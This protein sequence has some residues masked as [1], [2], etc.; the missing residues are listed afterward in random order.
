MNR[1]AQFQE[2]GSDNA[3]QCPWCDRWCLKD[4]ACDYVFSCGLDYTGT[5]VVGSGCGRTWCW[6]CGKKYCLPYHDAT[7]GVRLPGAKNH[8]DAHCC[9][10]EPGFE[11]SEYCGGGHNPHCARRW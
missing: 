4:G 5:F 11:E 9:K 8:H 3:K 10:L 1:R 7:T 2:S 6:T